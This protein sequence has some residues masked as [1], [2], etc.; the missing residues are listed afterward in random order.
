LRTFPVRYA[1]AT[2]KHIQPKTGFPLA[3]TVASSSLLNGTREEIIMNP[4]SYAMQG[5]FQEDLDE[6]VSSKP[7]RRLSNKSQV[8]V[9]PT[10]DHFRSRLIHTIEVNHIALAIG[11]RL[12]LNTSLIS[13]IA[14]A[15]DIGHTPFAHAGERT[16]REILRRELVTTFEA[17]E[18]KLDDKLIFHHSSNSARI[19]LNKYDSVKLPTISGVLTHSWAP[20][21]QADAQKNIVPESYEGQV[22]ALA[23]QLASINHDTEDIIE[24]RTY[25]NYDATRFSQEMRKWMRAQRSKTPDKLD[26]KMG[27]FLNVAEPGYGRRSRVDV[28]V[29]QVVKAARAMIVA[30]NIK[31]AQQAKEHPLPLPDD[32]SNFLSLYER[33]IR[34][35]V[36]QRESWFVGRDAMAQALVSTV[37]NHIWP[38]FKSGQ[39][40]QMTLPLEDDTAKSRIEEER[41]SIEHYQRFFTDDY[42][43]RTLEDVLAKRE[44][45]I[46]TWDNYACEAAKP[47]IVAKRPLQVLRLISVIDFVAGLTDRYCLEIFD[48]VYQGFTI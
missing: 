3:F 43:E 34:E 19:L 15:H 45:S 16:I 30:N 17:S 4:A 2:A 6:I 38:R 31:E 1:Q 27:L 40:T 37:F 26:E 20:W 41:L 28:M 10:R 18:Q 21:K 25:T 7:Y 23:D 39:E 32:W 12:D 42:N 5:D 24:G 44:S 13:A 35:V 36:V 22:V 47:E 11:T 14:M 46:K 48:R 9:K 33:F 8:M 29:E